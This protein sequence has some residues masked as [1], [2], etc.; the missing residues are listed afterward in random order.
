MHFVKLRY[1]GDY[2]QVQKYTFRRYGAPGK[3][4]NKRMSVTSEYN[5]KYN[6]KLR[7]ENLQLRILLNFE[8][9]YHIILKYNKEERPESYKEADDN[10]K[11]FLDRIRRKYKKANKSFKYIAITERGK[12]R[13]ALHHHMITECVPEIIEDIADMWGKHFEIIKMY[14]EGNY[15]DLAEY[16]VKL[17]TKEESTKGKARYHISRNLKKPLEKISLQIGTFKTDPVIPEGFI[18]VPET[19]LNGHNEQFGIKHQKYLLKR[20]D[21]DSKERRRDIKEAKRCTF[22]ESIKNIKQLFRRKGSG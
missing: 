13:E 21:K 4:R 15:K 14:D 18:L 16:F 8:N 3:K 19:L 7:A 20:S 12:R 2:L 6:N 9:G 1:A 5:M 10:L 17:E 11:R 22:W